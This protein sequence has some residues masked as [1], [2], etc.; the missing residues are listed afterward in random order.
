MV[1]MYELPK[2][3]YEYDALE[4]FIDAK[5]MEVHHSK[6]HATYVAKLNETIEKHPDL[7]TKTPRELVR[8]L[9]SI[10]EDIRVAVRNHAGGHLNHS[11]FWNVMG[12]GGKREPDG[13]LRESIDK[14]FGGYGEFKEKFSA[15]AV[16]IFGSGWCWLVMSPKDGLSIVTTQ[17]QDSPISLGLE[18]IIGLDVWEHA[19][20]LKYQNR[21]AEYVK[22]FWEVVNWNNV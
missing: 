9:E 12:P 18:P 6:H 13:G 15:S 4:P 20:Y 14:A 21:R 7:F 11:M 5:T 22:A 3:P 1:T 16:G 19:Y 17:N 2:L 8:D 10:P